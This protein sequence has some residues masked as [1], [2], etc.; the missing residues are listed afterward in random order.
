MEGLDDFIVANP[1]IDLETWKDTIM[2][3]VD[4]KIDS[5]RTNINP[6]HTN[7]VLLQSDVQDYLEQLHKQFVVVPI[8]KASNNLAII[9][10][11]YYAEVLLKEIGRLGGVSETYVPANLTLD[12]ILHDNFLNN[13]HFG[14][15]VHSVSSTLPIMYWMPKMHKNPIGFRFIVASSNCSTKP[16]S[17]AVSLI[18]NLIYN[19]TKGASG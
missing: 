1:D 13:E 19:Q 16:I 11:R 18:F 9:C 10:K 15:K 12:E 3:K 14:L 7:P 2:R 4:A 5:L 17:K 8:D 6:R